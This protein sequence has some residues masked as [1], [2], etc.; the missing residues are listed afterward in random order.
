MTMPWLIDTNILIYSYDETQE[1]HSSSYAFLEHAFSGHLPASIAHQNLLEFLA[2]VSNPKRVEHP[3]S[4]DEAFEKI[5]VY[6]ANFSLIS[7]T[8]KTFLT[9]AD[10]FARYPSIRERVFDLYL[11]ATAL[12]NGITQICTWNVKHLRAVTEFT[13]KTPE[14]ILPLL[15]K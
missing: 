1:L 7:P 13:V 14:E 15:K 8:S 2:V 11:V 12:D 6:A 9:F 3:L 4:P 10:L 5:A